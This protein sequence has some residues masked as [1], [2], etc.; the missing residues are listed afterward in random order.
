MLLREREAS[1]G[2]EGRRRRQRDCSGARPHAGS[3]G[4]VAERGRGERGAADGRKEGHWEARIDKHSRAVTEPNEQRGSSNS[5]SI[6]AKQGSKRQKRD[7]NGAAAAAE[8][9]DAEFFYTGLPEGTCNGTRDGRTETAVPVL[10]ALYTQYHS[11]VVSLFRIV[12]MLP[13]SAA[14][15]D[16]SIT[17]N[18]QPASSSSYGAVALALQLSHNKSLTAAHSSCQYT[19]CNSLPSDYV[20]S[21]RRSR[22]ASPRQSRSQSL[23]VT[24][25]LLRYLGG[26]EG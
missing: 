25:V 16:S 5:Q 1:R 20:L 9:N 7:T 15:A 2:R 22:S 8:W 12:D 26:V 6:N 13:T 11:G 21:L 4:E 10:A 14:E 17:T 23:A 19:N 18:S 24:P 3:R